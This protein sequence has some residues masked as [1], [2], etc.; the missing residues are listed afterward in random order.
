MQW[1]EIRKQYPNKFV[2]IG[3]IVEEKMSETQSRIL[4]GTVLKISD[5]GKEIRQVYQQYKHK[6]KEV[7]Y[8][9]PLTP[10]EFIV[11]NI[12]YKGIII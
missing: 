8:S 9:L 6:G 4:E 3:E 5:N 1:S 12:P 10:E 11:E 7:L 2:L